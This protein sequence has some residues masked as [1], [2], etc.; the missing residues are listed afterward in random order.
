MD[1]TTQQVLKD[2]IG[3]LIRHGLGIAGGWLV[4]VNA[5]APTD[6][7]SFVQI[8]TGVALAAVAYGW[9]LIQKSTQRKAV[10][11]AKAPQA[12]NYSYTTQRKGPTNA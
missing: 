3:S 10:L 9:S 8:G 1:D 7:A 5:L 2:A 11:A 4:G 12:A 6:Q